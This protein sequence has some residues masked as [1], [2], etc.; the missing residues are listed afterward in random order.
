MT[1]LGPSPNKRM[2][3]TSGRLAP[4]RPLATYAQC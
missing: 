1:E 3:L 4:D 2:K